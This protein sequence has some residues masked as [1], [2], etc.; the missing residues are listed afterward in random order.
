MPEPASLTLIGL[1]GIGL[2]RR[3]RTS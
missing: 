1:G 3:K 2:L